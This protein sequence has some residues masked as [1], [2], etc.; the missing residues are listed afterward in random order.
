MRSRREREE[1]ATVR[2]A[3]WPA[4]RPGVDAGERRGVA[5]AS[6]GAMVEGV[7]RVAPGARTTACAVL[8][9]RGRPATCHLGPAHSHRERGWSGWSLGRVTGGWPCR[10][11]RRARARQRASTEPC[12]SHAEVNQ[13]AAMDMSYAMQSRT[14]SASYAPMRPVLTLNTSAHHRQCS[15]Q[16]QPL[17][18]A[19]TDNAGSLEDAL[20]PPPHSS[21]RVSQHA[22]TGGVARPRTG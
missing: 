14:A 1:G 19:A 17:H 18:I 8:A 16:V 5:R 3:V 6:H 7:V 22:A 15:R 11:M 2:G 9:W 21:N 10:H 20:E 12:T 4:V 13:S